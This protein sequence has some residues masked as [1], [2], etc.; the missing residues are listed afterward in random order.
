MV[1]NRVSKQILFTLVRG[2]PSYGRGG[3]FFAYKAEFLLTKSYQIHE[4]VVMFQQRLRI[5]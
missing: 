4:L 1:M 2:N 3:A 5:F